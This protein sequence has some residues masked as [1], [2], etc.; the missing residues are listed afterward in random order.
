MQDH[1]AMTRKRG[2]AVRSLS[3]VGSQCA[4]MSSDQLVQFTSIF[5]IVIIMA[6][7]ALRL[8]F[9]ST[10]QLD[11]RAD[12]GTS[13]QLRRQNHTFPTTDFVGVPYTANTTTNDDDVQRVTYM[14]YKLIT[15][16]NIT[17]VVDSPC[18]G[19]LH[20]A[21]ALVHQ[22]EFEVPK[23]RYYCVL[24]SA[25]SHQQ[26]R[27]LVT[28]DS[29]LHL[30]YTPPPN[31]ELGVLWNAFGYLDP[32]SAWTLLRTLNTSYVV[33]PHYP[34]VERNSGH[35][36]TH[37]RVNVRRAPYSFGEPLRI[38]KDVHR[39]GSEPKQMLF[40]RSSSIRAL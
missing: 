7:E 6:G 34:R 37:G 14:L 21:P 30:V 4:R 13:S 15:S 19:S 22:L 36:A 23:F 5:V 26:A 35:S 12:A 20:W 2:G 24:N 40:Y 33:V 28:N 27:H 16:N 38:M 18:A 3:R 17:T 31:A 32:Q 39:N 8:S 11:P 25:A 9:Y 29:A 10:D 1:Q